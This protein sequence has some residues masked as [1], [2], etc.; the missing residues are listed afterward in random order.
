VEKLHHTVVNNYTIPASYHDLINLTDSHGAH[1][2]DCLCVELIS[3]AN[4]PTIFGDFY[5]LAFYLS[6][7]DKDHAAFVK[8]DV[9]G[10][11]NVLVRIHSECLT[12]D[13]IGSLRCDCRVQLEGSLK[14]I[15]EAGEGMV[16]YLR[17]EGRG[18]GLIN[19]LKAYALQD[20]GFDTVQANVELGFP[21]DLREYNIAAN[22]IRALNIKSIR[23]MTNN[24]K[25][26]DALKEFNINIVERVPHK[27]APNKHNEFYLKTKKEVS[28]HLL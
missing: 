23:L 7:D 5:A 24:P 4:L 19:K 26:I 18:I 28:K 17:Q 6:N 14:I 8:G 20:Q 2:G 1:E 25:K 15:E 9:I 13:A 22:M 12:G 27:F 11:E 21:D 3:A 16:I 10:K